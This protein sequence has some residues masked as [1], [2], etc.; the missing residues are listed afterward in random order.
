LKLAKLKDGRTS[1]TKEATERN[2]D[3]SVI[4][5]IKIAASG[6]KL[7]LDGATN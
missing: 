6:D 1:A 7:G 4:V 3:L 5:Y 2:M